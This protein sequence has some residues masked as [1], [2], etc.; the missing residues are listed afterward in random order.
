MVSLELRLNSGVIL[1]AKGGV[2]TVTGFT[3][4]FPIVVGVL[5]VEGNVRY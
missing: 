3:D 4:E 1:C 5:D 2:A